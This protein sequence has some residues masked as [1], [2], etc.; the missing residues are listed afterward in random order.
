MYTTTHVCTGKG[1]APTERQTRSAT[2]PANGLADP[3]ATQRSAG[4]IN[5]VALSSVGE[6]FP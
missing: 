2:A 6:V 1:G 5:R 4:A 3:F